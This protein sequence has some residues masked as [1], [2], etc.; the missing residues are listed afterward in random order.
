MKPKDVP[1]TFIRLDKSSVSKVTVREDLTSLWPKKEAVEQC[2]GLVRDDD[3]TIALYVRADSPGQYSDWYN[4]LYERIPKLKAASRE[5]HK[6]GKPLAEITKLVRNPRKL[7]IVLNEA[8]KENVYFVITNN[9]LLFMNNDFYFFSQFS[10]AQH[11]LMSTR[12][13]NAPRTG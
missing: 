4:E 7:Y 1:K 8:K 5:L 10:C 12:S 11:E 3:N 13:R 9:R 2:F 6:F